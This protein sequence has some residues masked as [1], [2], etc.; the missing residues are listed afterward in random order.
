MSLTDEDKKWI[1]ETLAAM[2]ATLNKNLEAMETTFN[3]NLEAMETKLLTAFQKWASP[4]E[5]RAN[6]IK[7]ALKAI[8]AEIEYHEDRIKKLENPPAA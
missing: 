1:T 7:S 3:E 5:A 6:A 8:D 2:E 4:A